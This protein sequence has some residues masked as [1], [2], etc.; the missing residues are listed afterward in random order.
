[1]SVLYAYKCKLCD[2]QEDC[3]LDKPV[4]HLIGGP[5]PEDVLGCALVRDWSC[6]PGTGFIEG[7]SSKAKLPKH[8]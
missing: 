2:R 7:G 4:E 1:M 6:V 5:C 3:W 8:G